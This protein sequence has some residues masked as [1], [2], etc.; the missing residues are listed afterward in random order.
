[1]NCMKAKSWREYICAKHKQPAVT[2][3]G[4]PYENVIL[5][6]KTGTIDAKI[7]DPNSLGIDD[8]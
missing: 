1:M 3:N 4:K 8:F 5:Q 2:K 6:D 7:W